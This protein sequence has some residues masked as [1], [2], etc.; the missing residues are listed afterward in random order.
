MREL[1]NVVAPQPNKRVPTVPSGHIYN[2]GRKAG[3]PAPEAIASAEPCFALPR[4]AQLAQERAKTLSET[5]YETRRQV[6][7]T[8][9]RLA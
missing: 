5:W 3:P 8:A 7:R 1:E 2:V 6:S 9:P 4:M